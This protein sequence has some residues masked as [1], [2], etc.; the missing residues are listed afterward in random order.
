M[1]TAFLIYF[2]LSLSL[3]MFLL[4]SNSTP[5]PLTFRRVT[6]SPFLKFFVKKDTSSYRG[7]PTGV[8]TIKMLL[9]INN[10]GKSTNIGDF[11]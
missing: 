10:K 4:N 11:C 7:E 5:S 2:L 6:V 9:F 8:L 3:I 1:S